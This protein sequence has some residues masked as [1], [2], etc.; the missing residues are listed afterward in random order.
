M[1]DR[2]YLDQKFDELKTRIEGYLRWAMGIIIVILLAFAGVISSNTV[3]SVKNSVQL[4]RHANALNEIVTKQ[5]FIRFFQIQKIKEDI[6]TGMI[7]DSS[8][9][10]I[11]E[12]FREMNEIERMIIEDDY[13]EYFNHAQGID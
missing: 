7:A 13:G 10:Y 3:R 6:I 5:Q 12:K 8:K 2:E 4:E 9:A 11:K 1:G